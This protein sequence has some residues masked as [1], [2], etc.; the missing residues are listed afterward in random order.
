MAGL[1]NDRPLS[2]SAYPVAW[3]VEIVNDA[4]H[5]GFEYV[6][7]EYVVTSSLRERLT[8]SAC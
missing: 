5:R 1:D 8:D 7:L 6:R 3:R 2:V 4:I